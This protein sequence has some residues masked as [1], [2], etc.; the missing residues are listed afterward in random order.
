MA[1]KASEDKKRSFSVYVE[2]LEKRLKAGENAQVLAREAKDESA[3][4]GQYEPWPFERF[5]WSHNIFSATNIQERLGAIMVLGMHG[6]TEAQ[7]KSDKYLKTAQDIRSHTAT[8]TSAQDALDYSRSQSDPFE[9]A[10]SREASVWGTAAENITED[11]L[12]GDPFDAAK[13]QRW[14]PDFLY[15]KDG[16]FNYLNIGLIVGGVAVTAIAVNAFAGGLG[17]GLVS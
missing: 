2:N 11:L 17:K 1:M 9:A 8:K 5:M 3:R 12:R 13:K 14:G 4:L 15:S 7:V 16:G 10:L 6:M